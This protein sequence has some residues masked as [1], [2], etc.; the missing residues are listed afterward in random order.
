MRRAEPVPEIVKILAFSVLAAIIYG[1]AHD[2]IT[3]R[4][5]I[6]YFTVGHPPL[7][8]STSPTML[9]LA[10]GI[11]ATW[12]V[13][14]PLGLLLAAAA[15]GG[16]R[17][18]F[19]AAQVVPYIVGLIV[20]VA[21]LALTMGGVGYVLATRG[22]I[23]L[24]MYWALRLPRD[25]QVPFLIDACMHGASY[26]FGILGGVVIAAIVYRRRRA[27]EEASDVRSRSAVL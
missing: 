23:A 10:W 17:P 7:I 1:V 25:V 26:V 9:G 2:Q 24:P 18:K 11:V 12:W 21:L 13:G 6:E 14:L 22:Y 15:R 3:A 16:N 27:T 8:R 20:T 5:C 4:I 19:S